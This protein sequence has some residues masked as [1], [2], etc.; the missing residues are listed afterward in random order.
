MNKVR[1]QTIFILVCIFFNILYSQN[2]TKQTDGVLLE[3][4]KQ[5][6][7]DPQWIKIQVC[8]PNIIR[9][10]AASEPSF[11]KRPS[12]MVDKSTWTQVP[13]SI[14][15]KGD[16]IEISTSKKCLITQIFV[17]RCS[18]IRVVVKTECP[19]AKTMKGTS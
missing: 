10:A 17:K 12:L 14:E 19:L 9:V 4:K 1:L 5:K 6:I 3:F 16:F 7:T 11:S 2:Y 15:K 18:V 8:T 13:F